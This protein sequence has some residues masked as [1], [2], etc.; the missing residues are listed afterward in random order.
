[1]RMCDVALL[2]AIKSYRYI[3]LSLPYGTFPSEIY[4]SGHVRAR[5]RDRSANHRGIENTRPKV[6]SPIRGRK[7]LRKTER[8]SICREDRLSSSRVVA[9]RN[10]NYIFIS[11][12]KAHFS[13][14]Y[15]FIKKFNVSYSVK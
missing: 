13:P 10:E 6:H 8:T 9:I 1:M 4:M 12:F 5:V 7:L 11:L 15:I 2:S 14:I 3:F